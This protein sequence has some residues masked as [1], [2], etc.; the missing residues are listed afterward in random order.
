MIQMRSHVHR[1]QQLWI[2]SQQLQI[3]IQF[4]QEAI[5]IIVQALQLQQRLHLYNRIIYGTDSINSINHSRNE[6]RTF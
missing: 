1:T 2:A 4:I 5:W 3:A 6:H